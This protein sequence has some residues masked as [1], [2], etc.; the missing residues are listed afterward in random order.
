LLGFPYPGGPSSTA[1]RLTAI[2]WRVRFT[3]AKMKGNAL[4]FSFSGPQNRSAALVEAPRS[5]R[6]HRRPPRSGA[7]PN[8]HASLEQWLAVT[9]P[10]TLDLLASFQP[11]SSMNC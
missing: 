6:R 4:D 2:R 7:R 5:G 1:W 8:R 9:Q 3:F 11:P 10:E